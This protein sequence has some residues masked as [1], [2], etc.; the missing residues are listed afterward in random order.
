ME[1]YEESVSITYIVFINP[2]WDYRRD[3]GFKRICK[4]IQIQGCRKSNGATLGK[5]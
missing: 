2:S 5:Y 1:Y 3:W 4:Q